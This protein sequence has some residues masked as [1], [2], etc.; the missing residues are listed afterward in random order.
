MKKTISLSITIVLTLIIVIG[1][2]NGIYNTNKNYYTEITTGEMMEKVENGESFVIYFFQEHCNGCEQVRPILN[3][4]IKNSGR[5]I[6]AINLNTA[7][8]PGYLAEVLHIQGSPTIISY[9]DGDEVGRLSTAFS[10]EELDLCIQ[11]VY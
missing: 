11:E 7:D 1:V 5:P 4:Y 6:Y 3:S 8:Y 10:S 9:K 2:L